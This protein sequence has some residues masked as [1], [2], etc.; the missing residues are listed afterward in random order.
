MS[1][2]T[3]FLTSPAGNEISIIN[4]V[5]DDLSMKYALF[6]IDV[7]FERCRVV[8]GIAEASPPI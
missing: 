8:I 4:S 6:F 7:N 3:P 2:E 5:I 1:Y